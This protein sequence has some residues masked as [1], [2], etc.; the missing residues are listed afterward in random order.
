M[1]IVILG[2]EFAVSG[3]RQIAAAAGFT[4][5]AS[6]LGKSKMAAQVIAIALVIGGIRWIPLQELGLIGMWAVLLF[7]VVSGADYFR[8]F[9]R[10]VDDQIKQRRRMELLALESEKKRATRRARKAA[11]RPAGALTRPLE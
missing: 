9:W 11:R 8:T 4:I 10:K 3:L 1:V 2:R 5:A 7:G 6:D